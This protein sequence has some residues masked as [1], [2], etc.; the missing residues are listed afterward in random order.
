MLFS[1]Q[2]MKEFAQDTANRLLSDELG[3][4]I[5]HV[6]VTSMTIAKDATDLEAPT[7]QSDTDV[8]LV[9]TPT[10]STNFSVTTTATSAGT[11]P[12]VYYYFPEEPFYE[13]QSIV[14]ETVGSKILNDPTR[15]PLRN[16]SVTVQFRLLIPTFV[17]DVETPA[18]TPSNQQWI[19]QSMMVQNDHTDTS[20]GTI[21]QQQQRRVV[22]KTYGGDEIYVEWQSM[23]ESTTPDM[24]VAHVT[25]RHDGTYL[26]D[27]IRPPIVQY[28]QTSSSYGNN[29]NAT[30]KSSSNVGRL[31]IYYD[32][33]CGIGGI[34]APHKDQF[35]RAGEIHTSWSQDGIPRPDIQDFVPPNRN[36][37]VDLSKYHAVIAFGDSLMLQLV[38][39][40]VNGG[41][42]SPNIIYEA[43]VCQCLS[44]PVQDVK[45]LL[46]KFHSWH[47]TQIV[48]ASNQ[49]QSIA[50]I[51]GSAV[52]DALRG[53]VRA[54][55]IDHHVAIREFVT[56]IQSI[57][58]NMDLYWKS[59]S[60]VALHRRSSLKDILN[61]TVLLQRSRYISDTVLRQLYSVQ[62]SLMMEL[63]VPFLDMFDAYF[64]SLPWTLPGS[65]LH[66]EDY[67]S[68]LLL[69][70]YWPGLKS[71]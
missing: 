65:A 25:D 40:Y 62:K 58:P 60:T 54:D 35:V 55:L 2:Q 47:G 53:C 6:N 51:V 21:I 13:V 32:Y 30:R 57:Y 42:W 14:E 68:S 1:S 17:N 45:D 41:F 33:S 9:S 36:H 49:S 69:S 22:P 23:T 61:N 52:W 48:A 11:A 26:L 66:Y 31:T 38:R 46:H 3:G 8:V 70:Y 27:F 39:Q 67:I 71:W 37:A 5:R 24:G 43:N 4:P 34:F 16:C 44:D 10:S 15:N 56:T 28:N 59:P 20:N 63:Q 64:L 18:N 12:I 19:L 7:S 50:V 29:N